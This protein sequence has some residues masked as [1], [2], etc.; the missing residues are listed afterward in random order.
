[1]M[2]SHAEESAPISNVLQA[3]DNHYQNMVSYKTYR[4]PNNSQTYNQKMTARTGRYAKH[5]K[6]LMKAYQLDGKDP[7]TV[8]RSLAQLK[9]ARNYNEF[10]EGMALQI[11]PSS[12]KGGPAPSLIV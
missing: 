10:S 2:S 12:V 7:I 8:L 11:I 4:L 5:I 3:T 6:T 1:M 9:R